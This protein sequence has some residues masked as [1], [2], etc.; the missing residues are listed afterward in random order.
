MASGIG[1]GKHSRVGFIRQTV[2]GLRR[3]IVAV[4]LMEYT[5]YGLKSVMIAYPEN[6]PTQVNS[7]IKFIKR[8]AKKLQIELKENV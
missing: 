6:T 8:K 1:D 7:G 5:N 4:E 2:I 3:E